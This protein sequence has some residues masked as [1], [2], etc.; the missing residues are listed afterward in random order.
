MNSSDI[1]SPI[2]NHDRSSLLCGTLAMALVACSAGS[3][4]GPSTAE[5]CLPAD[6]AATFA[7]IAGGSAQ[8]LGWQEIDDAAA[9]PH[10]GFDIGGVFDAADGDRLLANDRIRAIVRRPGRKWALNSFGGTLIAADVQRDDGVWHDYLGEF[11]TLVGLAWSLDVQRFETIRDG[12]DGVLVVGAHGRLE[13]ADWLNLQGTLGTLSASLTGGSPQLGLN[14]P[15][16]LDGSV[17]LVAS[18]YYVLR[19]GDTR[20]GLY[21]AVCNPEDRTQF[22]SLT[23]LFESGGNVHRFNTALPAAAEPGLL[24]DFNLGSLDSRIDTLGFRGETAGYAVTPRGSAASLIYSHLGIVAHGTTDAIGFLTAILFGFDHGAPPPGVY[25]LPPRGSVWIARDVHIY[26][27]REDLRADLDRDAAASAGLAG[28]LTVGGAPLAGGRVALLDEEGRL[29]TIL[30]A[31]SDGRFAGNVRPGIHHVHVD[32]Q[33]GLAP[34]PSSVH[35]RAGAV[36]NVAFD[37]EPPAALRFEIRG[38]DPRL[39]AGPRPMPAKVSLVCVGLCPAPQSAIFDDVLYDHWPD[40]LQVQAIVDHEDRVSVMAKRGALRQEALRVPAGAY[41]IMVT[42][43]P[44]FSRVVTPVTLTPGESRTIIARID[45]VVD[46]PGWI[47]ADT[48]VHS[49]RSFDSPVPQND[50]VLT[51]AAEGVEMLVSTEHDQVSDLRPV[52]TA[53]AMGDYLTTLAGTELTFF[54]LGHFNAFPLRTGPDLPRGGAYDPFEGVGGRLR[55]PGVMFA[56]LRASGAIERPVVQINHARTPIMG[57]FEAIRLDTADLSTAA[58]PR[59]FRMDPGAVD[60]AGGLFSE[61]FDAF[62]VYNGYG[63]LPVGLND[64]FAL[65]NVGRRKTGVAVSDTHNWYS[66]SAGNPRS[67]VLVGDGSDTP[68]ALTPEVFAR[69]MQAGRVI[70]SNGPHVEL[71]LLDRAGRVA[72]IGDVLT[73]AAPVTVEVRAVMPD[74]ITIDTLEVFANTPDVA[75]RSG[76]A[77]RQYPKAQFARRVTDGDFVHAGGAKSIIW[78]FETAPARDAWFV[79]V[80]RDEPGFGADHDLFPMILNRIEL[81]VAFTNAVFV[82][83]DGNGAFDAPGPQGIIH[84]A[85]RPALTAPRPGDMAGR[86]MFTQNMLEALRASHQ[87]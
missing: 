78:T 30:V 68:A 24:G 25:R 70:G 12:S 22:T 86:R 51:F 44:A 62:E 61:D 67:L 17:P 39:G 75:G 3:P 81:P 14:V 74:W 35:L 10:L 63:D 31:D 28:L 34:P 13:L 4:T 2:V 38:V 60:A 77:V 27:D 20:I 84:S 26:A 83:V 9:L 59:N 48:H 52:I 65:L 87:H 41:E 73:T 40:D 5:S 16:P 43:G 47:G 1:R 53:L 42:R 71:R 69:A 76:A 57:Y 6:L 66:S 21:T 7:D 32:P 23:D 56:D 54:D 46:E 33:G 50:R 45:R 11:G 79:A 80:A 64:L 36:A 37:L 19:S 49:V 85:P 82:D 29:V 55:P 8:P 72:R 58:D 15:W 18:Q